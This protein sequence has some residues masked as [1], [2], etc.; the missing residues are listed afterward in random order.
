MAV[1]IVDSVTSLVALLD[2]LEN[3]PTQPPSLYL[4]LEGIRLSRYGSISILQIFVLPYYHSFLVDVHVLQADAFHISSRFGTTLK[5]I[6][7]S[8]SV[9]KVFFDVRNDSD[10]LFAHYQVSLDGVYDIQLWETATRSGLKKFLNGLAKCI[11]SD[12]QLSAEAKQGW[13]TVKQRGQALFLPEHGGS[14]KVLNVRP[15]RPDIIAYC[16]NDVVYLPILWAIYSRKISEEWASR[17]QIETCNRLII[18]RSISYD[19]HSKN[20]AL[21]PWERSERSARQNHFKDGKRSATKEEKQKPIGAAEVSATKAAEKKAAKQSL[22]RSALRSSLQKT[23]VP[24]LLGIEADSEASKVAGHVKQTLKSPPSVTNIPVRSK[25]TSQKNA[26]TTANCPSYPATTSPTWVRTIL[27]RENPTVYQQD[28]LTSKLKSNHERLETAHGTQPKVPVHTDT[29]TKQNP[30]T[31]AD[32]AT[33]LPKAK[34]KPNAKP[35]RTV[36]NKAKSVIKLSRN[37]PSKVSTSQQAGS[38]YPDWDFIGFTGQSLS[39]SFY[40]EDTNSYLGNDDQN[41]GA[42]DKDCAWCGH[43]MD[44]LD[45]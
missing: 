3:L 6:L 44:G 19:P 4:D 39:R 7:E 32:T 16:V 36:P 2:C 23:F 42:C 22:A 26:P 12:V 15:M 37:S 24:Q 31:S 40:Y 21:S 13:K 33:K 1:T 10:A 41:Y 45:I 17:V 9:P 8:K 20:K 27:D 28:H 5:S 34:T 43:C 38:A 29:A 30:K 14:Y 18:S 11:E 25:A 35:P